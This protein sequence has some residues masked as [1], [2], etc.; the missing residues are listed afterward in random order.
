MII[1]ACEIT[2]YL[3]GVSS[4]KEK[5]STVKS[6]LAKVRQK[7]NVSAAEV[8]HQDVWQSAGIGIVLVTNSAPHANQTLQHVILWI[9]DNYPQVSIVNHSIEII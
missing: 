6:L 5:R 9:E 2:L 8:E 3:P 1:G 4:L 7:F